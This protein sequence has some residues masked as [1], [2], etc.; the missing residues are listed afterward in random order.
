MQVKGKGT[1]KKEGG[2]GK[3]EACTGRGDPTLR[4]R[5]APQGGE[6]PGDQME[7][8]PGDHVDG[9]EGQGDGGEGHQEP[10]DAAA[11]QQPDGSSSGSRRM[12]RRA[13]ALR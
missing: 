1:M 3:G 7:E 4:S 11:H 2:R 10:E 8:L 13:Q 9:Q 12:E 6:S 5:E